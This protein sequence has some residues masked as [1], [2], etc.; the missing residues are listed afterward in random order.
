MSGNPSSHLPTPMRLAA[1]EKSQKAVEGALNNQLISFA[2][3][4]DQVF[5]AFLQK[6]NQLEYTLGAVVSAV[7]QDVVDAAI[8]Q[9]QISVAQNA[10]A[11]MR[12][13]I[14]ARVAAGTLQP[15]SIVTPGSFVHL[16]VMTG[17][18]TIGN[19]EVITPIDS[20]GE[21]GTRILGIEVGGEAPALDD[22][23]VVRVLNVYVATDPL[24]A[25]ES[26]G[27]TV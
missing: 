25:P 1:L 2:G 6:L 13:E 24:P 15:G 18:P 22:G 27:A 8:K 10:L 7:G 17:D 14:D 23:T 21:V 20:M 5:N 16:M 4:M 3:K 9:R 19:Q 26:N 11:T 12:T